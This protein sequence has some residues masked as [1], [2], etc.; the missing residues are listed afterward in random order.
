METLIGDVPDDWQV[1]QLSAC[2]ELQPGPA[3]TTLRGP[4]RVPGGVPVVGAAEVRQ[5][6]I[7]AAPDVGIPVETAHGL[8]HYALTEG[9]ILL[10]RVGDTTR[11][12]IATRAHE[13][14]ILGGSCVRARVK[15]D[16]RRIVEPEYLSSYLT[17]PAVTEWIEQRTTHGVMPTITTATLATLPVVLP[18]TGVQRGVIDMERAL[19]RKIRLHEDIVATTRA[20]RDVLMPQLLSG[21]LRHGWD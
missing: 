8:A 18:P 11:H 7:T 13:G 4:R 9:D 3:G 1:T 12:G 16:E 10:V 5:R 15:T 14:W 17:H 20:L 21:T 6:R 2:C 19:D